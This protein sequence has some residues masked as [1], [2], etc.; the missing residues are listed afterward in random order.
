MREDYILEKFIEHLRIIYLN[1][2]NDEVKTY[3][4]AMFTIL[5]SSGYGK[6][7]LMERLGGKIPVFYSSLQK[8]EG[9]PK[10]SIF[11]GKIN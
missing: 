8:R 7:K 5:Q 3:Y 2:K 1:G 11:F 9:Y 10:I 4:C 6:S